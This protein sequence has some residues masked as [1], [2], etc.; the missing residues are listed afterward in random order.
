MSKT[1]QLVKLLERRSID[2]KNRHGYVAGYLT[3]LVEHFEREYKSAGDF[4]DQ[5]IARTIKLDTVEY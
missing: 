2:P 1:Q 4:L 5:E 3:A